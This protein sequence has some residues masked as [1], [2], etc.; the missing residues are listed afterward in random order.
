V[1]DAIKNAK[2]RYKLAVRDAIRTYENRFSDDLYE[3]LLAKDMTRFWKVWSIW[4]T[5]TCKMLCL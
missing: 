5:K 3:H 2:Y 4:S 1:F